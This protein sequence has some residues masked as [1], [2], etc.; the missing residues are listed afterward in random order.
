M[1]TITAS[2]LN[3][4]TGQSGFD[5]RATVLTTFQTGVHPVGT[6]IKV[7]GGD[8]TLDATADIRGTLDLTTDG[9]QM[10]PRNASALLVPYGNE[11]FIERAITWGNTTEW[12]PQ[13]YF[14]IDT[15][16]QKQ[17]PDGPIRIA[18]TDRMAG[19]IDADLVAPRQFLSTATYGTV[20]TTLV[21]EVYPTAVIEWDDTTNNSTTG[22][23]LIAEESRF[24]FINDLV[25]ALGKIWYWDHR[26]TLVIKAP[27]ATDGAAVWSVNSGKD[28]VLVAMDRQLTRK[29]V[30]NAVVATGEAADTT[31]PSR[32]LAYDNNPNSPTYYLGRFGPV[33]RFYSS[34][35]ITTNAQALSAATAILK[36]SLGLPY[37]VNFSAVPNPALEP[38]DVVTVKYPTSSRATSQFT[39]THIVDQVVIPLNAVNP[40]T[41]TTREQSVVLIG[42]A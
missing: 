31:A 41:S 20:V 42:S 18:A 12:I 15:P 36:R 25:T 8:I 21:R 39:E 1:K 30:F 22:R 29:G 23:A 11:I 26:G 28:G 6:E 38:Y 14:R 33:P 35:F 5:V 10:W 34:P 3:V 2:A 37:N 13:G 24:R 7:L 40:I 27:P 4:L 19:I 16:E 32:A 17:V 9:K